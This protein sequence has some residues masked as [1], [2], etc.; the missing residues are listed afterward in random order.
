M[1][2]LHLLVSRDTL[3]I[4]LVDR[5]TEASRLKATSQ[6]TKSTKSKGKAMARMLNGA[7]NRT[8]K[9]MVMP[10]MTSVYTMRELAV[11]RATVMR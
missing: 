1:G 10:A 4:S 7:Q 11:T 9:T 2:L 8:E 3:D 6:V 5:L